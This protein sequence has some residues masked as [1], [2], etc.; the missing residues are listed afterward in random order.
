MARFP[1]FMS[2]LVMASLPAT[3][4]K[5][6]ILW[7]KN[8]PLELKSGILTAAFKRVCTHQ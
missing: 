3:Q 1:T 2:E 5:S 6:N 8:W 4:E 7:P